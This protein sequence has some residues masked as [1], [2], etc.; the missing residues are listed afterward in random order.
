MSKNDKYDRGPSIM[1]EYEKL[2]EENIALKQEIGECS[3]YIKT[4][5]Q[6]ILER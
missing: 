2:K 3:V 1:E 4:L 6:I 5:L